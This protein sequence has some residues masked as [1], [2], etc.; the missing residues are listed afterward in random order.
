MDDTTGAATMVMTY[1]RVPLQLQLLAHTSLLYSEAITSTQ[2]KRGGCFA[3]M[4]N[5]LHGASDYALEP[6]SKR[7]LGMAYSVQ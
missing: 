4:A 1:S 7:S 3:R 2:F 5:G 6:Q